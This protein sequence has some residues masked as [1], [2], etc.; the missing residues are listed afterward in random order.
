MS[1][2]NACEQLM[3]ALGFAYNCFSCGCHAFNEVLSMHDVL[4]GQLSPDMGDDVKP[5][6][7]FEC[8]CL[9]CCQQWRQPLVVSSNVVRMQDDFAAS[10]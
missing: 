3:L 5:S 6:S 7:I 10:T 2:H 9:L 8:C 1:A 4:D